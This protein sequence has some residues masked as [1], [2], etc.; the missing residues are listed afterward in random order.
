MT[1]QGG[2]SGCRD[3]DGEPAAL[4]GRALRGW[5][6]VRCGACGLPDDRC[7]CA[8][9]PRIAARTRVV[10]VMHRVE[11][12]RS[13]NTGRLVARMLDGA[14]VRVRGGRD[15]DAATRPPGRRLV[16][17]PREDAR[18]L[19]RD[20][21][22]DDLTLVVPD[23]TWAQARRIARRDALAQGA[24]AVSLSEATSA[25]GLRRNPRPGALCTLEAVIEAL[26]VLE[27]DPVAEPMGEAFA[28]WRD[29][30]LAL[31]EGR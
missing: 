19:T 13:T 30:S 16:L 18:P 17:Y 31:R 8:S 12:V 3:D 21:A 23:G 2:R 24:E 5:R 11:S 10:V 20:D 9:L 25:Y 29:A 27:G 28:R 4:G 15:D 14:A 26:R 1:S 6:R 7:V 22:A